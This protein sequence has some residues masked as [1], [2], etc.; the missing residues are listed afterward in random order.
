MPKYNIPSY[1]NSSCM[2][3]GW[4]SIT[5]NRRTSARYSG[6]VRTKKVFRNTGKEC[7]ATSSPEMVRVRGAD[8]VCGWDVEGVNA[9]H[10]QA[11]KRDRM[12]VRPPQDALLRT[13]NKPRAPQNVLSVRGFLRYDTMRTA[14]SGC[15][16]LDMNAAGNHGCRA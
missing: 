9:K 11:F 7:S 4:R 12:Y 16:R 15:C 1:S 13:R 14:S 3:F 2:V 6:A 8:L 10:H 5:T